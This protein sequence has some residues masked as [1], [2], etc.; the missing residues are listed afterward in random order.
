MS[1]EKV[2]TYGIACT[3]L[4][5]LSGLWITMFSRREFLDELD[6]SLLTIV[7]STVV[8]VVYVGLV[9]I[10]AN[11]G[12]YVEVSKGRIGLFLISLFGPFLWIGNSILSS[13][14]IEV[15]MPY[16]ILGGMAASVISV[17]IL[18]FTIRSR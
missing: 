6:T 11:K 10:N 18:F 3:S 1:N 16:F 4:I 17:C 14:A 12:K 5:A 9:L 2:I 15:R 7:L 13:L 8:V